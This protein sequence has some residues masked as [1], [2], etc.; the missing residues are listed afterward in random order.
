MSTPAVEVRGLVK[1]YGKIHALRGLDLTVPSGCIYGVVGPNG[2]GKTTLFSILCGY[3][4][5]TAGT[6]E[7]GGQPVRVGRRPPIRVSTYPQDALMLEGLMVKHHL[8]YYARLDGVPKDK[9]E[10]EASRVLHMVRLPE[11]WE[12]HPKT[13]SHG[14]RKRVGIAQAFLGE[15]ELVILDEPTAGLDPE[16]ARQ[17]RGAIR[18][19]AKDRT[20]IVSSHDLDQVQELCSTVAVL[21]QGELARV[22][23]MQTLTAS[24]AKVSFKL[25]GEPTEE[26]LRALERDTTARKVVWDGV[27]MR[28]RIECAVGD[29]PVEEAGIRLA[30]VLIGTGTRFNDLRVGERLTDVVLDETQN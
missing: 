22:A 14:Q 28:L 27:D 1:S 5:P 19:V 17:I 20:V 21:S 2:A 30:Q 10:G 18:D 12:R 24:S 8:M 13:L 25:F 7:L 23:E 29:G 15:P 16:S 26:L 6:V 9:V 3:L 11:V 4:Q